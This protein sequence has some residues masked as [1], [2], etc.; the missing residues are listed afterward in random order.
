[1]LII[2]KNVINLAIFIITWTAP[3]AKIPGYG[4][5]EQRIPVLVLERTA[6]YSVWIIQNLVIPIGYIE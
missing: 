3:F 2:N 6:G 4:N 5:H 1:M